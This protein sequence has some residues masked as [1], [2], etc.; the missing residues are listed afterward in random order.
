M[1]TLLNINTMSQPCC[2]GTY[3]TTNCPWSSLSVVPSVLREQEKNWPCYECNRRFVSSEQLQQ[4]LNM[5]DDKL[6]SVTR[7]N[8]FHHLILYLVLHLCL[9]RAHMTCS[10]FLSS[11]RSRG[12][13]RGRGRRRFGTGR[14]PGRPPKFI[15][16]DPPVDAVG[17]KTTV[18]HINTCLAD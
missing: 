18:R 12:R 4:H 13:G 15:R 11:L 3:P 8:L 5:H 7:Y 9:S 1:L 6:N 17:D 14:R 10:L 2:D 16:L